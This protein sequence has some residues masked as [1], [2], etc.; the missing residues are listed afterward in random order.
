MADIAEW[1]DGRSYFIRDA[2]RVQQIFIEETQIALESTLIEESFAPVVKREIEAFRGI[3]FDTAPELKGYVSTLPKETA[4][5]ILEAQDEDP[6]LARWHY[7]IGRSVMFTSDVKNRWAADWLTWDG[8]GKFWAQLVR[9]TLRRQHGAEVDFRVV[10]KGDAAEV[11]LR[12]IDEDGHYP[13][14]LSPALE[15]TDP[16][17]AVHT[18]AMRQIAPGVY[19]ASGAAFDLGGC[20]VAVSSLGGRIAGRGAEQ[21]RCDARRVLSLSGRVSLLPARCDQARGHRDRDRRS[22]PT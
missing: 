12:V 21:R 22:V 3:D 6:L 5:V 2:E 20:A 17:S 11:E 1:G 8:Y 16:A 14:G 19:R 13:K 4:E 7:G 18:Q 9:E 10:R 15:I